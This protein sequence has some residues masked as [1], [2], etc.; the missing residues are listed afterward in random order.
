MPEQMQWDMAH[1]ALLVMD[2]ENGILENIGADAE[3]LVDRIAGVLSAARSGGLQVFYVVVGFRPGYPEV[4]ESNKFFAPIR[5]QGRLVLGTEQTEVHAKLKPRPNEPVV[6]KHRVSGLYGTDLE[7][8]LRAKGIDTLILTGVATSGVILSTL[9]YAADADY[10]LFVV[11]DCCADRDAEVHR[12]LTEK[13]FPRQ[14][15]V[16]TAEELMTSLGTKA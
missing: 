13:V 10:R 9:R 11:R 8:L 5:E 1:T 7:L 12:V 4:S 3:P 6:V 15:Q 16:L 2:C 14:A